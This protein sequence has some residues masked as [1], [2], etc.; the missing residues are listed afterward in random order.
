[1]PVLKQHFCFLTK[2]EIVCHGEE[3]QRSLLHG[4]APQL[5]VTPA[6]SS[7]TEM[8]LTAQWYPLPSQILK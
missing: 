4:V 7:A 3:K 8:H 5:L 1:M 2:L 6:P